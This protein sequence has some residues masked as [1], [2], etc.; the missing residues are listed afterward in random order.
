MKTIKTVLI[1]LAMTLT[2]VVSANNNPNKER[3]VTKT[4][5]SLIA[6]EISSMLVKPDFDI[7]NEL[8]ANVTFVSNGNNEI[9][10]LKV[11]TNN[12]QLDQFIKSRLN[13]HTMSSIKLTNNRTYKL[14][15]KVIIK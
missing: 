8:K 12:E 4:E 5:S 2:T 3:P 15:V 11:E 1:I 10:V 7:K 13:Y 6:K 14:P 9:V